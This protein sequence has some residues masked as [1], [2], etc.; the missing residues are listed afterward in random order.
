MPQNTAAMAARAITLRVT[1]LCAGLVHSVLNAVPELRG[2]VEV[3]ELLAASIRENVLV[4]LDVIAHG[5]DLGNVSAPAATAEYA[6]R[7]AQ[8]GI[9][10][11]ALLRAYRLGQE[12]FLEWWLDELATRDV[13]VAELSAVMRSVIRT[14]SQYID[15]VVETLLGV[16]AAEQATW[17]RNDA[18]RKAGYVRALLSG[19]AGPASQEA[20][21]LGHDLVRE[22]VAVVARVPEEPGTVGTDELAKVAAAL[23]SAYPPHP[24]VVWADQSTLWAWLPTGGRAITD[25]NVTQ[26]VLAASERV[27]AGLGTAAS[28]LPGFR[29]SHHQ[30]VRAQAVAAA[31]GTQ[32]P[33]VTNFP[34]ASLLAFLTADLD[35]ARSWVAGVLG[36]L[37]QDDDASARYRETVQT[38]LATNGSFTETAVQLHLHKN[39]VYYRIRKAE[40]LRGRPFDDDRVGVEVALLAC[41]RLGPAVLLPAVG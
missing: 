38:F 10:V 36:R 34:D 19:A 3:E 24:I 32:G 23:E 14:T 33:V 20:Q 18:A 29:L 21:L 15:M 4:G 1:E 26:A 6:R 5:I 22:Q 27:R 8:R 9:P 25:T 31:A 39:T 37:A 35:T 30:A 28:G 2:D 11:E 40:E 7:L 12:A 16:Y 17:L 13:A 41:A